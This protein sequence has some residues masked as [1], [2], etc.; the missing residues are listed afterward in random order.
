MEERVMSTYDFGCGC[1]IPVLDDN[2]KECDGLPS[3][4]IDYHNLNPKCPTTWQLFCDGRTKGIFQLEKS[5]GQNWSAKIQPVSV[6]ELSALIA[7]IRPGC[8]K[9]IV[10]GKNMTQHFADRKMG[11]EYTLFHPQAESIIGQTYGIVTYQEQSLALAKVFAGFDLVQADI[12]RRAIGKKKADVMAQLRGEFVEGCIKTNIIDEADAIALFDIIE[13]SNRYSFNKAHSVG[14]AETGYWCAYAKAHFPI[15]FFCSWLSL[16]HEKM[17]P[18]E[19]V[20]ELIKDAKTFSID[21][22]PPSVY[23]GNSNFSIEKN[24]IRCGVGNVKG[25]GA[26]N[27]Q[28]FLGTIATIEASAGKPLSQFTWSEILFDL[29]PQVSK[30]VVNNLIGVGAFSN[31]GMSRQQMLFEYQKFSNIKFTDK[32]LTF[33]QANKFK[34]LADA[35]DGIEQANILKDKKKQTVKDTLL[36][37]KNP[38]SSYTDSIEYIASIEEDLIGISITCS[39]LDACD[40][41]GATIKCRDFKSSNSKNLSFA[42]QV[43]RISEWRPPNGDKPLAFMTVSDDSGSLEVMVDS[44]TY[45]E[46]SFLL[47][48]GNTILISGFKNKKNNLTA[49][50]VSQI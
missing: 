12:L 36:L 1:K 10:G 42:V 18:K 28:K 46:F 32:E 17:K 20:A 11:E 41:S 49:K 39:K 29:T 40:T 3:M 16:A 25:V 50:K 15:H 44:K 5:L 7:L 22:L 19:E 47:F 48:K 2:L 14:Y 9:A 33:I 21:I 27:V 37:V 34:S 45:E 31:Y 38:P 24:S 8:L 30:T 35:L 43:D 13:K 23:A 6:E 4:V 26:K